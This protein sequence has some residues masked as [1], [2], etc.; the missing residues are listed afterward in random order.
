MGVNWLSPAFFS[1]CK[2]LRQT[3]CLTTISQL[4]LLFPPTAVERAQAWSND[5]CSS[6]P[7]PTSLPLEGNQKLTT[8]FCNEVFLHK[9]LPKVTSEGVSDHLMTLWICPSHQIPAHPNIKQ[10]LLNTLQ[11]FSSLISCSWRHGS[12][13]TRSTS[14]CKYSVYP[15]ERWECKCNRKQYDRCS[16]QEIL[17]F[18]DT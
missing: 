4:P 16:L 1:C 11:D 13:L 6:C 18:C 17:I 10:A 5:V 12:I 9:H 2:P 14:L 3:S 15:H 7:L 8:C